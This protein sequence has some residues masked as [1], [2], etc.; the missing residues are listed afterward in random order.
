M[1]INKDKIDPRSTRLV[2][3]KLYEGGLLSSYEI[4]N[5]IKR[6]PC[7]G[8][9]PESELDID[10]ITQHAEAA[11][12]HHIQYTLIAILLSFLALIS[13]STQSIIFA[14][15]AICLL[16][17]KRVWDRDIALKHFS[18]GSYVANII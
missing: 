9:S 14:I 16:S 10:N 3:A 18:K 17:L 6:R 13:G 5:N 2:C 11:F 7:K 8:K 1:E 4:L 15:P 12:T